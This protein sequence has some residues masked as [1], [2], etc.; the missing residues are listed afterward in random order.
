MCIGGH[1]LGDRFRTAGGQGALAKEGVF[2]EC[3]VFNQL[4]VLL[5][6]SLKGFVEMAGELWAMCIPM[7][8]PR[9]WRQWWT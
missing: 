4:P 2:V 5:A 8:A 7:G 1:S 9:W 3:H 6:M